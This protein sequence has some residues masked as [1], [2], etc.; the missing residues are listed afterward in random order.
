MGRMAD[1]LFPSSVS[2]TGISSMATRS[3]LAALA[4]AC[5]QATG[6]R[7]ALQS[8]G[9]VDAA[10]RVAEGEDFDLV[11]L[12]S[13][14]LERLEAG[15]HLR[16]GSRVAL[17]RSGVSVAVRTG[18]PHPDLSSE[19]AVRA[20]VLAAPT[21]GHSTGPSGVQLLAL[22]ERWGIRSQ[23]GERL[24]QAP[25]GV[26]VAT[27]VARGEVALGFQQLSELIG[28]PGIEVAGPLPEAIRIDTVFCGA[29][30][31]RC[32]Q[33]ERAAQALAFLAS[34]ATASAKREHGML[35]AE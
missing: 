2:L 25:A 22:F 13:D 21:V 34:P 16:A 31:V 19:A 32:A 5:E 35:S 4:P 1:P 20:A 27:L 29:I 18:T 15:G 12:A 23:L 33:P 14:A 7:L 10:R 8:V 28:Q 17:V 24:V 30:G 6:A 26:P 3:L 9:G 11:L